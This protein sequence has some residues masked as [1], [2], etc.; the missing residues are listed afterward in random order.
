VADGDVSLKYRLLGHDDGA[1]RAFDKVGKS[2]EGLHKT[3]TTVGRV[4][5]AV[6]VGGFAL[7]GAAMVKGVKDA[8]SYQTLQL[9][10]Q[11]VLKSTGNVA[12]TSVK[13]VDDLAASLESM[14]GVD[15]ELII[16]SQNVLLTFTGVRN[17]AGKNNDIFTQGTKAALD[18]ST[19]LGTDLQG[20]TIQVGKALNDPIKGVTALQRVGVSFTASQKDQIAAMVKAGD[21]MGAQKLILKELSTEFGGAAKAAG[22]G[23]GGAM[24]RVQDIIGDSFRSLGQLL[25][26]KLT[27]FANW[28]ADTGIPKVIE[29][30]KKVGDVLGSAFATAGKKIGEFAGKIDWAGI[31]GKASDITTAVK[32]K[33]GPVADA[34]KT[35]A[36]EWGGRII[37]GIQTGLN[38]GNWA[39]LGKTLGDGLVKAIG[40][41]VQA[42]GA[43][44]AAFGNFMGSI[45][46]LAV[47]KSVGAQAFPFA[48]GFVNELLTGVF[49][50][51]KNHPMDV[52]LFFVAFIPLGKLASAFGPLRGLIEHL[53]LGSW[54]TTM[55]D[56]TA[57]PV[58][59]AV[60]RFVAFIFRGFADGF[61][62]WFPQTASRFKGFFTGMVEDIGIIGKWAFEKARDF[63]YGISHGIGQAAGGVTKALLNLIA[64]I[65]RPFVNAATWL[66]N[67]G[68]QVIA[69]LVGGFRAG[70]FG[71]FIHALG[72][73]ELSLSNK[74][75]DAPKWLL[76]AGRDVI[77]GLIHGIENAAGALW[78][79]V[80]SIADGIKNK[81]KDALS[82]FSP[83]RVMRDEVGKMIPL[84][85]AEG[86]QAGSG[87]IYNVAA[88]LVPTAPTAYG[89]GTAITAGAG[90]GGGNHYHLHIPTGF[91]GSPRELAVAFSDVL[92]RAK[93]QGI[94]LNV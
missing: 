48:V 59:D 13:Q 88:N 42:A 24:A 7:L 79:K 5:G 64:D 45:D 77:M 2:A 32:A 9:K 82:I 65:M 47:G 52:A 25:L 38:T 66:I 56:H 76:N 89:V 1:S 8:E 4:L 73:L 94:P 12:G 19:A 90:A 34:I 70:G 91:V 80:T 35:A 68:R 86:M 43:I 39:P 81:L 14:S 55:L 57:A 61:T 63:V 93:S 49:T 27:E 74:F 69:G 28:L 33:L 44:T 72:E 30:S 92:Q 83:S 41:L 50:A 84:G 54:F 20:A 37:S 36:Q 10:T 18:L 23:F 51:A 58:F 53:P 17:E 26:P 21:T 46:W 11:A 31:L 87:A 71:G 60:K 62:A 6:A 67:A 78:A 16:N 15:E 40:S 85:I 22:G 29:F 75:A 3:M